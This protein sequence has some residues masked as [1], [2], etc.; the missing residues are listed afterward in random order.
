M[1]VKALRIFYGLVTRGE[2]PKQQPLLVGRT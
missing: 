1:E 2:V